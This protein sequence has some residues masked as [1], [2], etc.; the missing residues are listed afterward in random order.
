MASPYKS[1]EIQVQKPAQSLQAFQAKL[2]VG[3]DSHM[4]I[5]K[6]VLIGAGVLLAGS[7]AFFGYQSWSSGRIEKH[8]AAVAALQLALQGDP[9]TPLTPADLEKRMR[10]NLP[11]LEA[12]V[13][14]APASRKAVTESM[15]AMWRLELDGKGGIPARTDDAWSSLRLAQ[16]QIAMGQGQEALA[17]LTPL[18][19]SAGPGTAWGSLYWKTLLDARALQG[20]RDQALKDYAEYKQRFRESADVRGMERVLIGI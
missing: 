12:L 15:L 14:S 17:T 13:Q 19:A 20:D 4:R 11:K 7:I 3:G 1:K 10:E 6:P 18:R 8:E 16:R 2:E 5:I 9:K